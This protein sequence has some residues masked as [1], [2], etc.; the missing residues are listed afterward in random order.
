MNYGM[1]NLWPTPV[2]LETIANTDILN[3]AVD[4]I[5]TTVDLSFPP[6][7]FQGYDVL[8]EGGPAL[9]QFKKD[10]VE[11]LFDKYLKEVYGFS[12]HDTEYNLRSWMTGTGHSYMIPV[13]NHSGAAVSA[14]FY[15]LCE[16]EDKGGE[17]FLIDPRSNANR[18]YLNRMK[19]PFAPKTFA[20]KSGEAL[21]F[22]SYLYHQTLTF[23]GN[24]RLA[25]PVDLYVIE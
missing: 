11:P 17:L 18:G 5:L 1:N 21:I 12:L 23:Q 9:R 14:V 19:E 10:V 20:P 7:D 15:L 2:L 6:S 16:E 13:H 4:E 3:A 25:M 24:L 8:E 22:P